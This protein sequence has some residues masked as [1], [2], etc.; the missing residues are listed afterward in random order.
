MARTWADPFLARHRQAASF[1]PAPL[2]PA[3]RPRAVNTR[4]VYMIV[5]A[6]APGGV[7]ICSDARERARRVAGPGSQ[8]PPDGGP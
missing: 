4:H 7:F 2:C 1:P 5:K 8:Y 3:L 6:S